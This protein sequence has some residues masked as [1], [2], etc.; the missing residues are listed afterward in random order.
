MKTKTSIYVRT[1]FVA[2]H[3]W[4]GAPRSVAFLRNKHRHVFHVTV[5]KEVSHQDREIEF[6]TY[7]AAIDKWIDKNWANYFWENKSCEMFAQ[8][9]LERFDADRVIVSED[10]ENGAIVRRVM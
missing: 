8:E 4:E 5:E 6:F 7:K 9:L 10:G 1:S 3:N 2:F